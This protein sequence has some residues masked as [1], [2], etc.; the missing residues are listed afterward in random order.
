MRKAC[1]RLICCGVVLCLFA[2]LSGFY[3]SG[4]GEEEAQAAYVFSGDAYTDFLTAH[5]TDARPDQTVRVEGAAALGDTD[6]TRCV[7]EEGQSAL[8]LVEVEQSG[9]YAFALGYTAIPAAT[10]Y[11]SPIELSLKVNGVLPYKET[12]AIL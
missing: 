2:S 3:A 1:R 12:G 6:G 11:S 5:E 4:S 8:F 7:I 10:L 9:L